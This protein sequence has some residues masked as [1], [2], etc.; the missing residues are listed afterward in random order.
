MPKSHAYQITVR[1]TDQ[2]DYVV[3]SVIHS[4]G[5]EAEGSNNLYRES[6][7]SRRE[8]YDHAE[9]VAVHDAGVRNSESTRA[10]FTDGVPK[11]VAQ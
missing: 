6:F 4:D 7:E 1:P 8:A 10:F 5:D 9:K 11:V 3:T 2:G